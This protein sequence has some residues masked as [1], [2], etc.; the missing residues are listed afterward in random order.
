MGTACYTCCVEEEDQEMNEEAEHTQ[1]LG[2]NANDTKTEENKEEKKENQGGC[3]NVEVC[4]LV[5]RIDRGL[6]NYF[7]LNGKENEY[8]VEGPD[9]EQLTED[10]FRSILRSILVGPRLE[11]VLELVT[12]EKFVKLDPVEFNDLIVANTSIEDADDLYYEIWEMLKE[13]AP[14]ESIGLFRS[15][16]DIDGMI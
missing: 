5:K 4:S 14:K 2:A 8:F 6:A 3:P 7:K 9:F 15:V 10:H 12:W 11:A 13:M 16:L 1:L